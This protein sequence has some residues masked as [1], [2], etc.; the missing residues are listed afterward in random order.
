[1]TLLA[2]GLLEGAVVGGGTVLVAVLIVGA[3]SLAFRGRSRESS[4]GTL[5]MTYGWVYRG[6][7]VFTLGMGVTLLGVAVAGAAGAMELGDVIWIPF[8]FGA[9]FAV[10][11]AAMTVE[12]FR[13]QVVVTD[14][15]VAGRGWVGSRRVPWDE[16]A[17]VRYSSV[18]SAFVVD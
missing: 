12:G 14:D 5:V 17:E 4:E 3:V 16:V 15:G 11:G 9:L 2:D 18:L 7:A 10:G 13:R 6:L 8:A 1:M